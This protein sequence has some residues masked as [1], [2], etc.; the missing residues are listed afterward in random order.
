MLGTPQ[1]QCCVC[2]IL[3]IQSLTYRHPEVMHLQQKTKQYLMS[4]DLSIYT[5]ISAVRP[6]IPCLSSSCT[7]RSRYRCQ[8]LI[9]TCYPTYRRTLMP[10][11]SLTLPEPS[12]KLRVH[13]AGYRDRQD[14]A[15]NCCEPATHA[16][17]LQIAQY[18][19]P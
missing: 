10:A 15:C 16:I 2:K 14:R 9:I 19:I 7:A 1:G 18:M 13:R 6:H 3:H 8:A 12:P 5:I 4:H 11:V 17:D